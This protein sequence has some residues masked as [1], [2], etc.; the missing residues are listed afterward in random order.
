[1]GNGTDWDKW[2]IE[3]RLGLSHGSGGKGYDCATGSG[4]YTKLSVP[5]DGNELMLVDVG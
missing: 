5:A 1:M 2:G 3:W 4:S